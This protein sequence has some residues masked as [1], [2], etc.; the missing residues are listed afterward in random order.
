MKARRLNNRVQIIGVKRVKNDEGKMVDVETVI[1][2]IY[3]EVIKTTIKEFT[4]QDIDIRKN[5]LN[6]LVRYQQRVEI[7][8]DMKVKFKN[9]TYKITMVEPNHQEQDYT[10][11][12]CEF[13]EWEK[14]YDRLTNRISVW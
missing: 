1:N 8:S 7:E 14:G 12:G 4:K 2:T 5:T 3:C 9:H 11:L 10:L 6:L 13:Y